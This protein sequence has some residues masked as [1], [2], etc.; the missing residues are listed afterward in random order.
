KYEGYI[1]RQLKEVAKFK[2]LE[3]KKIPKN[4]DYTK[5]QGLSNELK[6]KL[7]TVMPNS[8]GQ[9][10][11]IDGMTPSALSVLMIALKSAQK[12]VSSGTPHSS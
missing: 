2:D 12:T 5:I 4:F 7:S 3:S 9:A 8:L 11:R 6:E 10:S 1:Q